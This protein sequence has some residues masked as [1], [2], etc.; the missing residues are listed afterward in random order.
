[1]RIVLITLKSGVYRNYADSRRL[2]ASVVGVTPLDDEVTVIVEYCIGA[3]IVFS[4]EYARGVVVVCRFL[5][6]NVAR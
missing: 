5:S 6:G 2:F 3:R 1:M 4:V